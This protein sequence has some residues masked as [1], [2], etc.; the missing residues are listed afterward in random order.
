MD[1]KKSTGCDAICVKLLTIALPY[2]AD[3]LTYIYSLCMCA[4][5]IIKS[6]LENY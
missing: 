2:I 4:T 5:A 6:L 1:N 3:S